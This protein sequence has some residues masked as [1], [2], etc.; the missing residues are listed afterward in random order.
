[1]AGLTS[2]QLK[3]LPLIASGRSQ[4]EAADATGVNESTISTW[5]NHDSTFVEALAAQRSAN[6]AQAEQHLQ[7]I[8]I[9]AVTALRALLEQSSSDSVK[10][11]ACTYI[12]DRT[13]APRAEQTPDDNILPNEL[14]QAI[15]VARQLMRD[16]AH[17]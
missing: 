3:V 17:G 6:L 14:H 2:K 4:R 11:R 15:K 13:I 10:L 5:V 8:A 16:A 1:M 9:D 12:I 7:S